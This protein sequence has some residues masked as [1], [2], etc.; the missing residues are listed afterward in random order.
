M[1]GQYE[2]TNSIGKAAL[3]GSMSKSPVGGWRGEEVV[4][5]H[6]KVIAFQCFNRILEM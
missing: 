6:I 4:E 1:H 2:S 3:G 5:D